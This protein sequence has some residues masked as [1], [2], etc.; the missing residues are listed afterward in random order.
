MQPDMNAPAL[1]KV[2]RRSAAADVQAQLQTL[3]ETGQFKQ[4]DRLPS[5][6]ELARSFGVSRPVVRE[7]LMSLQTLGLTASQ[8]GKGTF[9]VS[10]RVRTPL[11]VGRYSPAHIKEVR[12][13][14]EIPSAE[15]AAQ[16]RTDK[17]VG[18][19]AALLARLEDADN[20]ARRNQLDA[21]FHVAIATASGNPLLVKLIEDMRTVLEEHSLALAKA[22]H[23]RTAAHIE[24]S[25]IYDAIV[26]RDAEAAAVAMAAHLDAAEQAFALLGGASAELASP[27]RTPSTTLQSAANEVS[28]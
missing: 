21:D 19:L 3:I 25:I 5:E 9:V 7:A 6:I 10:D 11:L 24:H 12:R 4:N 27:A 22:P 23:R 17:D 26:R 20:P 2:E 13:A 15:L 28:S 8:S 16:R 14:L 18:Q 1:I